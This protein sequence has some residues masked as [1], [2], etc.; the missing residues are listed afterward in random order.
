MEDES[1]TRDRGRPPSR[2]YA[3]E[4]PTLR[5]KSSVNE[6]TPGII[7]D[8]GLSGSLTDQKL[9]HFLEPSRCLHNQYPVFSKTQAGME[10]KGP[11]PSAKE[12]CRFSPKA[13]GIFEKTVESLFLG[14]IGEVKEEDVTDVIEVTKNFRLFNIY[15]LPPFNQR[16]AAYRPVD[17]GGDLFTFPAIGPLYPPAPLRT[18]ARRSRSPP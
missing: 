18:G 7:Q 16:A 2:R 1:Q 6:A 14:R 5:R 9:A 11:G 13:I 3:Q 17:L 15:D 12:L 8:D 10:V 4:S